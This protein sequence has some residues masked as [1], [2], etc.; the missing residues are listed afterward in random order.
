[1][2]KILTFTIYTF[3]IN[4][5]I[6]V[7]QESPAQ[8]DLMIIY[9]AY[10]NNRLHERALLKAKDIN[11]LE[12]HINQLRAEKNS[13]N[14][15]MGRYSYLLGNILS[16]S[17]LTLSIAALALWVHG[18]QKN[19]RS[20]MEWYKIETRL[21]SLVKGTLIAIPSL[22]NSSNI[23]QSR[24]ASDD[25]V[26]QIPTIGNSI[27]KAYAKIINALKDESWYVKAP[28]GTLLAAPIVTPIAGSLFGL[29]LYKAS[30]TKAHR[31]QRLQEIEQNI[32]Q[33]EKII[34]IIKDL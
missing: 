27:T 14:S 17:L 22:S 33:D 15:L 11:I 18:M 6:I 24:Y 30:Q 25:F 21:S 16:G 28:I 10:N 31:Q 12:N 29:S 23:R 19:Y 13:L 20:D 9:E 5:G 2:K 26:P 32:K 8:K 7:S 34:T 4:A 1:M 3:L